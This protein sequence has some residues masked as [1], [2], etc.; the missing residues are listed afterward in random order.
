MQ[1]MQTS[2]L[3]SLLT[4]AFATMPSGAQQSVTSRPAVPLEPIGAI[5][6]AFSSHRIVAM[7]EGNHGNEQGHAFRLSLIRDERFAA[8]VDDIVVEVGNSLYQD[9]MDRFVRGE[10]VPYSQ[11]RQVW[12]NITMP[13]GPA[14][15]PIYEE[16]FRAVRS[17]N[18]SLPRDRQLR[19]LL[20][21]PPIN[22]DV[23][24]S[25]ADTR[26]WIE[27]REISLY[28]VV[29]REVLDKGR[30]AL[31]IYGGWHLLRKSLLVEPTNDPRLQLLPERLEK[32]GI[33]MF[34]I[35]TN[36]NA[37]LDS[38]QADI[39]AWPKPSLTIVRGTV[40]GAA[41]FTFFAPTSGTM[42]PQKD[43]KAVPIQRAQWRSLPMEEQFDAVLYLGP[44]SSI[45]YTRMSPILCAD[46]AYMKMRLQRTALMREPFGPQLIESLKQY[47]ASHLPK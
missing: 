3:L 34:T 25:S 27:R 46:T 23:V 8:T 16:F 33:K 40:L 45:T 4:L 11:L 6:G 38:L 47:C 21:D 19:V 35:W 2:A 32:A 29:Q 22:W 18:V 43:G 7:D 10:D 37:K 15:R 31:V 9:V 14:D 28:D 24:Q 13:H 12:E 39:R 42:V 44:P 17:V 1:S 20:G 41:D 36:T 26:K 5:V 30:R